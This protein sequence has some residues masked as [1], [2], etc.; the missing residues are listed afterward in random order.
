M[1]PEHLGKL[2]E[3]GETL[4]VEFKS[5]ERAPFTDRELVETAVCLANRS[6]NGPGWLLIGVEG[7]GRVTAA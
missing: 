2:I 1:T 6:S 7:D 4:A 3:G 5:E